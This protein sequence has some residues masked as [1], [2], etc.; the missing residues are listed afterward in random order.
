MRIAILSWG[1][2]IKSGASR[3]LATSG[4]WFS[5]GPV[6]PIE[7][8]RISQSGDRR[9]CLTLVIDEKNG[10]DVPTR[11]AVSCHNNLDWA[12]SNLRF[13]ENITLK[14]SVGYV[15]LINHTERGWARENHPISCNRITQWAQQHQFDAVIWT[16]LLSNFEKVLPMPF[17]TENAVNY[18]RTL[19][20]VIQE[21]A[22]EYIRNTPGEVMTPVRSVLSGTI[23]VHPQE[24]QPL[25]D[26]LQMG[27]ESLMRF[28]Q[29]FRKP[30]QGIPNVSDR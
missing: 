20:A 2:L 5:G 7:Y 11:Y 18:V 13:V 23:V 15:N 16:S 9:G 8:S 10:V 30:R 21:R 25:A 1:S 4:E 24:Q 22:M 14:Y 29:R 26:V 6:L 19:P 27:E 28:I 3:G 12:L 17:T